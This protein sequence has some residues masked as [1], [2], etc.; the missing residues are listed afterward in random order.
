MYLLSL[1]LT[2][3]PNTFA[4]A[5]YYNDELA[6]LFD[7]QMKLENALRRA[8]LKFELYYQ[9]KVEFKNGT[10][11]GVEAL[12]RWHDSNDGMRFS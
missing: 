11:Y 6:F 2:P 1:Y 12:I 3:G 9:P 4:I 7:H 8:L 5:E 10:I